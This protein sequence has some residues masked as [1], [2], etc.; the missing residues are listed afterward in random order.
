MNES[1]DTEP[2]R[3]DPD[4]PDEL[5]DAQFL[6]LVEESWNE[7]TRGELQLVNEDTGEPHTAEDAPEVPLALAMRDEIKH[8]TT[9]FD[10]PAD[11]IE[12]RS[13]RAIADRVAAALHLLWY[14][15]NN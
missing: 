13:D 4:E 5:T 2:R 15:W 3:L 7:Q 12:E 1:H 6:E 14:G 10:V 11:D 8:F 9:T